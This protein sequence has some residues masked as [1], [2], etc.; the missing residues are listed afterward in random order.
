MVNIYFQ[1]IILYYVFQI[2]KFLISNYAIMVNSMKSIVTHI[3]L[4][5]LKSLNVKTG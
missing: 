3:R 1:I 4:T 5:Q 2:R